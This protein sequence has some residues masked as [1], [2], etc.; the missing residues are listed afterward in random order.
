MGQFEYLLILASV[1]LGLAV[2]D[3]AVSLNRL[4][5]VRVRWDWLAPLAAV[6]A[7]LKITTQWWGWYSGVAS[8]KGM[9]FE[10]YVAVLVSAVLLFLM[11]AAS[12]PDRLEE[13]PF[14]LRAYYARTSRR[15]WLLFASQTS[16][17]NATAL[18]INFGVSGQI[19]SLSPFLLIGPAAVVLAFIR[20]RLLHALCLVVLI[21][22]YATQLFGHRLG[23]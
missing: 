6:L 8:A 23:Q 1:I 22:Y 9:T 11:A 19:P 17:A 13:S 16:V 20:Y 12:L 2:S 14:D 5:E 21:G 7:F 15:Y 3:I 4:L 18:W 10:N